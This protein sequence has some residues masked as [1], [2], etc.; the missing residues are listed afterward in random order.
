MNES[1][2]LAKHP[3]IRA[4]YRGEYIAVSGEKVIAHGTELPDVMREAKKTDP[5]PLIC[6]VPTQE[7]LIV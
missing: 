2:W 5:D 4:R 7:I 6:K 3:E 1:A